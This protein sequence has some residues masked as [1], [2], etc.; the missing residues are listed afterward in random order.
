VKTPGEQRILAGC[1]DPSVQA[2]VAE[3]TTRR[4]AYVA[5]VPELWPA[6]RARRRE[7]TEWILDALLT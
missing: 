1:H 5:P 7:I 2:A 4:I 3:A 6:G